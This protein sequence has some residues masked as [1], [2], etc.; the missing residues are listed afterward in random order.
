MGEIFMA[1]IDD[2][3]KL[4]IRVGTIIEAE[5]FPEAKKPAYKLKIDFG[6]LGI[7]NSSAQITKRYSPET[8]IGRQVV[9]VTNFPPRKIAGFK[10]DV[11]VLGAMPGNGDCVL[12][13]P[14]DPVENGTSIG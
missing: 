5:T 9:A 13:K 11:L 10:S 8:L 14:D 3:L 12:L 2:F 6:E 7:K 1:T 4:D